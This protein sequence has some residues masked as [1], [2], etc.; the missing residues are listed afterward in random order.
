MARLGKAVDLIDEASSLVRGSQVISS[1][2][3]AKA[4]RQVLSTNK[5]VTWYFFVPYI[6]FI[7][8]LF[9][10]Q[11]LGEDFLRRIIFFFQIGGSTRV[12][13]ISDGHVEIILN[14]WIIGFSNGKTS[15]KPSD[16]QDF[17]GPNSK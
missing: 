5:Q 7:W 15:G 2:L 12:T 6:L 9:C 16:W 8:H 11:E 4:K 14:L 17:F 3:V 13:T 1:D 10:L